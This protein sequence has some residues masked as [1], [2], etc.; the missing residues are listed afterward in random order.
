MESHQEGG[1]VD[2]LHLARPREDGGLAL[3]LCDLGEVL[4]VT[5]LRHAHLFVE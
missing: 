5:A 4:V 3:P 1:G 2:R